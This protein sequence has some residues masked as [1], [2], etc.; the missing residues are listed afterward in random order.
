MEEERKENERVEKIAKRKRSDKMEEYGSESRVK[1]KETK[2]RER[3]A[4]R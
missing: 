4:A 1:V 3:E 2:I